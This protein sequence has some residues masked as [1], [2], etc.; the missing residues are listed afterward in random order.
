MSVPTA[1]HVVVATG[2]GY[3]VTGVD[4]STLGVG[5]PNVN[6]NSLFGNN[7]GST[8]PGASLTAAQ[9]KTLLDIPP[10]PVRILL[11]TGIPF[12]LPA[13]GHMKNNG[14][15][16]MGKA[17]AAS[18]TASFSGLSGSGVTMTMSAASLLGTASDV[19]RVLTIDDGGTFKYATITTHSST[20]VAT[21]TLTGTLS[22]TGPFANNVIWL[23]AYR[24]LDTAY[25]AAYVYMPEDVIDSA[26][27][28]GFYYAVMQSTTVG[29]LYNNVYTLL[30]GTPTIPGSPTAFSSTGPGAY[31]QV[32][33]DVQGP[34]FTMPANSMGLNGSL[35]FMVLA[36]C[37]NSTE[38]KRGHVY[39]TD[40][41]VFSW[42]MS[43]ATNINYVNIGSYRC[44][45]DTNRQV[46]SR[47][48]SAND[49]GDATK[50]FASTIARSAINTTVDTSVEMTMY[51]GSTGDSWWTLE[52]FSVRLITAG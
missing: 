9:A 42:L 12:V 4:P 6:A 23:T 21:V 26:N 13:S 39:W 43:S 46:G 47:Q 34:G 38:L 10:S 45:G 40:R 32:T 51:V 41:D 14:V 16:I 52:A 24:P 35:E 7:T 28:A 11:Q 31:T 30:S 1:G 27:D 18:A 19:G 48:G 20:T 17:P 36:T 29:T 37:A 25:A 44:C 22:G 5:V 2:T 33:A 49:S 8:A 3:T 15:F 50:G